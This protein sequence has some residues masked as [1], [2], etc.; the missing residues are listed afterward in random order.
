MTGP[1]ITTKTLR[2][3]KLNDE[4]N[5]QTI[6]SPK[7]FRRLPEGLDIRTCDDFKQLNVECRDRCHNFYP[8]DWG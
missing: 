4:P 3:M 7:L 6:S 8:H 5:Y 1:E 2:V